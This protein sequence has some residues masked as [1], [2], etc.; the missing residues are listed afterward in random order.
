MSALGKILRKPIEFVSGE[1]GMAAVL[2]LL[3]IL[4]SVLTIEEKSPEG[5][6]AGNKLT[7][8]I[9]KLTEQDSVNFPKE[10]RIFIAAGK[11]KSGED[12]ADSLG[13]GLASK[14]IKVIGKAVGDPPQIRKAIQAAGE[15]D[16]IA[17]TASMRN[18]PV[19]DSFLGEEREVI[20]ASSMVVN[21]TL[22]RGEKAT[23]IAPRTYL[24]PVF[25]TPVNLRNITSQIAVIAI[26]A[27]GMTMV[28]ITA[29]IDLSVGSM[30][31][32]SAVVAATIIE[33]MGG[34]AEAGNL[35]FLIASLAGVLVCTLS[36]AFTGIM[37]SQFS[38]PPFI[39]TLAMM[40]VLRG[41]AFKIANNETISDVPANF[42]WLGNGLSYGIPNCV[43]LMIILYTLAHI[44]MNKTQLGRYI[45]AIGANA[46]ASRMSGISPKKIKLIVYAICG[47]TAGL[48]GIVMA[49][50]LQSGAGNYGVTYELMVIAAVV[51][52]GTSLFGGK[53]KVLGTLIGAFIIA[54]ITN[55]M[56]L[57]LLGSE[58]QMIVLGLVIL[59][60]ILI[61]RIRSGEWRNAVGG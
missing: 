46:E 61:E 2:L 42:Q 17:T 45:Y 18:L 60:A 11:G 55:G 16:L 37:V 41:I 43:I 7:D 14:G 51:V 38:I 36:G 12:F 4:F 31:A 58:T 48:G 27:I 44:M 3:C 26:L 49:S 28:I 50:Q 9:F 29:G 57:L 23:L 40:Q 39:A 30:I 56:N 6:K 15:I 20:R 5:T 35:A 1:Y 13:K 59:V 34:A 24:W 33:K 25:L 52:G 54:V 21:D 8:D 32:L 22:I 19:F 53:G 47:A 10:I